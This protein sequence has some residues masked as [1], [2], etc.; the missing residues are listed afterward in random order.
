MASRAGKCSDQCLRTI[1]LTR[2]RQAALSL[3][4]RNAWVSTTVFSLG[5]SIPV[6]MSSFRW[7]LT[8]SA[9]FRGLLGRGHVEGIR[10]GL[11]VDSRRVNA[12]SREAHVLAEPR[13]EFIIRRILVGTKV[14]QRRIYC[15]S[16]EFGA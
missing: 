11:S 15:T 8:H 2:V 9:K 7:T 4:G 16:E 13:R 10:K 1:T 6:A 5:L 12:R 3:V 14:D